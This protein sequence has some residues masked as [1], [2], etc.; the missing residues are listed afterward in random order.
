M[1]IDKRAK[2]QSCRT[3]DMVVAIGW[4]R[5]RQTDRQRQTETE[6]KERQTDKPVS[7]EKW[8]VLIN[9]RS[10]RQ[11]CRTIDMVVTIGWQRERQ[12]DRQRQTDEAV[13]WKKWV[14]LIDKRAKRQSCRTIEWW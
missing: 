8:V 14:V 10:K 1:L 7:W 2:R 13:S 6:N 5:D 12:T 4:R 9:R 3:I 11:S